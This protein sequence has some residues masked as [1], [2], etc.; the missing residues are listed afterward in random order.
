MPKLK[1]HCAISRQRTGYDFEGLHQWI[2]HP[3]EEKFL[4]ADHR[5]LR[6][7]YTQDEKDYI[8]K[9]W[10]EKKGSGWGEKAVIEWLFHIALDNL[11]TAFKFSKSFYKSK[12]FNATQVGITESG[13]IHVN[14]ARMSDIELNKLFE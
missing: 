8:N 9:Y 11:S 13:F 2:D 4:G 10:E 12:T 6:H 1:A 5:I 14:F 3:P 7:A